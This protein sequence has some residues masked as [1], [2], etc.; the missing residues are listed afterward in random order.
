MIDGTTALGREAGHLSFNLPLPSSPILRGA[1]VGSQ[2]GALNAA[3]TAA[4]PVV[5]SNGL[6]LSIL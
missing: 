4:V 5:M 6:Q 1:F 2:I 3:S